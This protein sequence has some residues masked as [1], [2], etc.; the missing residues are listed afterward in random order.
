MNENE[1]MREE[2]APDWDNWDDLDFSDVTDSAA[3]EEQDGEDQPAE[4]EAEGAETTEPE[5]GDEAKGTDQTFTLKHLDEVREVSRDEV[6]ALAQ[7]GMDY[8]RIRQKLD[9]ETANREAM[10]AERASEA[11]QFLQELADRR[12]LTVSELID[13]VRAEAL[14]AD[15]NID[16]SVALGRIQNQRERAAIEKERSAMQTGKQQDEA[17]QKAV[18][19]FVKAYPGVKGKDIPQ[20]VWEEYGKTGDLVGAYRAEENRKLREQIED[21]NQKLTAQENNQKNKSRSTGSQSSEGAREERD[22]ITADW[23]NGS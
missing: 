2:T 4:P 6:I 19:A 15:E 1:T 11:E 22:P 21:L 17:H 20:S 7:K 5:A 12:K 16:F 13:N 9:D 3:D 14:A 18:A 23:Y 10:I 8:D